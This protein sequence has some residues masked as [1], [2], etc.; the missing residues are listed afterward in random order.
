MIALEVS[1]KKILIL[2]FIFLFYGL[3]ATAQ[4]K[5]EIMLSGLEKSPQVR[6]PATGII[7]VWFESDTLYISGK[8]SDLRDYYW[9][10]HIHYGRRGE[11]GNRLFRLKPTDLN[12]EKTSGAFDPEENKFHLRPAQR[13]ALRD[14]H[15]YINISSYRHQQGEIRGQIPSM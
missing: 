15:L 14:G 8:F 3:S 2:L 9:A 1:M 4:S 5:Y 13:E 12:E 11:E 7:E 6:T 10:G